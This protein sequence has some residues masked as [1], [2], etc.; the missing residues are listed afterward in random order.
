[1]PTHRLLIIDD[2]TDFIE[3]T[4]TRLAANGYDVVT[5]VGGREGLQKAKDSQPDLILLDVMMPGMDGGDVSHALEADPRL[6]TIPIVHV[7]ALIGR[8]EAGRRN[9]APS[10]ERFLSKTSTPSEMLATI[11][12]VLAAKDEVGDSG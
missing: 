9:E 8:K 6:R 7:T 5:A 10:D 3:V 1:M 12:T 4:R 2:E 11:A